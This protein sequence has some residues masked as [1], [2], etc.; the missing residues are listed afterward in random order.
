MLKSVFRRG[1]NLQLR[2]MGTKMAQEKTMVQSG[3]VYSLFLGKHR[4]YHEILRKR[5]QKIT[6]RAGCD[7]RVE[8]LIMSHLCF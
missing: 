1:D 3:S 6:N 7:H 4:G 2:D 5:G 8:M